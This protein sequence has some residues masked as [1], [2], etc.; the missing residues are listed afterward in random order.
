MV[1]RMLWERVYDGLDSKVKE[2]AIQTLKKRGDYDKLVDQ[3]QKVKKEKLNYVLNLVAEL[4]I[5][6]S[7]T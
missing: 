3:L 1:M 5:V 4:M 6:Y 2:E 7:R